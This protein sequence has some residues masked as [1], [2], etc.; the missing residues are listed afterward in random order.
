MMQPEKE[1][2]IQN[3][4]KVYILQPR[5]CCGEKKK[6]KILCHSAVLIEIEV[7]LV[8][9]AIICCSVVTLKNLL[10]DISLNQPQYGLWSISLSYFKP[11][12]EDQSTAC[13][14]ADFLGDVGRFPFITSF[15]SQCSLYN[16]VKSRSRVFPLHCRDILAGIPWDI[17]TEAR[18]YDMYEIFY[19]ISLIRITWALGSSEHTVQT[20]QLPF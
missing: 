17:Q 5:K 18:R 6:K 19:F 16:T 4:W 13:W 3:A 20:I 1:A 15:S 7:A 2:M 9:L 12:H 10:V 11:P 14:T 8:Q